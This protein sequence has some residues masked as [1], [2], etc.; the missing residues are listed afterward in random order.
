[1]GVTEPPELEV[2]P[3]LLEPGEVGGGE[4][5]ED[6]AGAAKA[7]GVRPGAEADMEADDAL[8]PATTTPVKSM[9]ASDTPTRAVSCPHRLDCV[10]MGSSSKSNGEARQM[11]SVTSAR[12]MLLVC[13]PPW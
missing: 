9:T 12:R 8:V 11:P 5:P 10:V 3:G 4:L 1:M 2:P 6:P 7:D 13:L